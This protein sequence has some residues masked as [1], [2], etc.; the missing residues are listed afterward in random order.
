M[1]TCNRTWDTRVGSNNSYDQFSAWLSGGGRDQDFEEPNAEGG[2][3]ILGWIIKGPVCS[4][5][6]KS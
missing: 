4:T 5:V 6:G 1:A 3:A 2:I